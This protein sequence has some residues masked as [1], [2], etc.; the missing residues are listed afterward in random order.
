[1]FDLIKKSLTFTEKP[2]DSTLFHYETGNKGHDGQGDF[3]G[4][5]TDFLAC[6][7]T[8][9]PPLPPRSSPGL[10]PLFYMSWG[11]VRKQATAFLSCLNFDWLATTW[12]WRTIWDCSRTHTVT[13]FQ[14]L[15]VHI[16]LYFNNTFFFR[17]SL[18]TNCRNPVLDKAVWMNNT[19]NTSQKLTN[20]CLCGN[21][22]CMAEKLPRKVSKVNE[23][24]ILKMQ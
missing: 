7:Q 13:D 14:F 15:L 9:R 8:F 11:G 24:L 10:C 3:F 2:F 5:L 4:Y 20:N 6:M 23:S 19:Q 22:L 12:K 1:M 16:V 21:S 17:S 18:I